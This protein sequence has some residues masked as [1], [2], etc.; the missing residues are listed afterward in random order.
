MKRKNEE[1]AKSAVRYFN[2]RGFGLRRASKLF[3]IEILFKM[4]QNRN[5]TRN[6]KLELKSNRNPNLAMHDRI[7]SIPKAD[8]LAF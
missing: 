1:L 3:R 4:H 7:E 2:N 8:F 6:Q 5:M